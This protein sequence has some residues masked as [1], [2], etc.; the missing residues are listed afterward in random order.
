MPPAWPEKASVR[1]SGDHD[2]WLTA[3]IPG[4]LMRRSMLVDRVSRIAISLLPSAYTM[5]AN[6]LPVGDQSPAELMKLN[7]S[8]CGSLDGPAS[9]LMI[10]PVAASPMNR[11]MLKRFR[12]EKKAN[13]L[14]SGLSVGARLMSPDRSTFTSDEPT[15]SGCVRPAIWGRNIARLAAAQSLD[16]ES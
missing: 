1:P 11:S 7:A 4:S 10:L 6:L 5:N 2:T 16:S 15:L 12:L 13:S 8:K 14:P 9:F 3:P